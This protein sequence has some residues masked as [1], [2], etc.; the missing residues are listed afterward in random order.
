MVHLVFHCLLCPTAL[1]QEVLQ[2]VAPDAMTDMTCSVYPRLCSQMTLNNPRLM[3]TVVTQQ[4]LL[5]YVQQ[6]SE[7]HRMGTVAVCLLPPPALGQELGSWMQVQKLVMVCVFWWFLLWLLLFG[8]CCG[9]CCG[10]CNGWSFNCFLASCA[11]ANLP[12]LLASM[13][14][15]P[16]CHV[17]GD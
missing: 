12:F 8:C 4:W 9:C 14:S 16:H 17:P 11:L 1:L 15:L 5:L 3:N 7:N 10:C 2:Q 13:R 6:Q